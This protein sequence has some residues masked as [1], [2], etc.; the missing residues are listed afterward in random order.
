M[1]RAGPV[2]TD[3]HTNARTHYGLKTQ[4][5]ELSDQYRRDACCE[6]INRYTGGEYFSAF[7]G[8]LGA[9]FEK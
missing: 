1:T 8:Q 7:C 5:T 4:P 9:N 6:N 2:T 3:S